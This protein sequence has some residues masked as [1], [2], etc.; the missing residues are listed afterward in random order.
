[1]PQDD[2]V[3]DAGLEPS[4]D[5]KITAALFNPKANGAKAPAPVPQA[6]TADPVGQDTPEVGPD[7]LEEQDL[8]RVPV[9]EVPDAPQYDDEAEIEVMV[10]GEAVTTKLKDLKAAYSGDKAIAKRYQEAAE[11]R[12]AAQQHAA[13]L[14][15]ANQQT[16]ERIKQLDMHLNNFAE[17][18]IN[19]D[20][21]RANNPTEYAVRRADQQTAREAQARL[22]AEAADIQRKQEYINSQAT[23]RHVLAEAEALKAKIPELT[24]QTKAR[25]FMEGIREVITHYGFSED[26]LRNVVDHRVYL[27]LRDAA[28]YR[29]LVSK[30]TGQSS[31]PAATT[32]LRAGSATPPSNSQ[33]QKQEADL[34]RARK[35]GHPDDVA[36]TLIQPAARRSARR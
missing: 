18:Q 9:P 11:A 7:D 15:E 3:Q 5:D 27:A 2:Q 36:L 21:L 26:E 17:P 14:W 29:Q 19:W 12:N 20:W 10:D 34:N 22:R 1:M 24:D 28:R 4:G 33:R 8:Q 13:W 30:R 32:T 23:E 6:A 25:A 16:T 31:A 35:T